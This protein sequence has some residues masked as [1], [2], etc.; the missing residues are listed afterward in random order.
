[1]A[2]AAHLVAVPAIVADHLDALVRDMLG[3]GGQEVGGGEDLEV[4]ID[5]GAEEFFQRIERG[6]GQ[7]WKL[8]VEA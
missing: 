7:G 1:M 4:A 3:D 8:R 2:D 6:A 5:L